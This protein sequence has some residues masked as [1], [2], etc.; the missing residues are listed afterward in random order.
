MDAGQIDVHIHCEW[1]P[2]SQTLVL[3]LVEVSKLSCDRLMRF[4]SAGMVL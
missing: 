3:S 4:Y 2:E 1:A